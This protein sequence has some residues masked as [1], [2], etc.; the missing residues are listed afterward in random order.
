VGP[1]YSR[2]GREKRE[3]PAHRGCAIWSLGPKQ[4]PSI[5]GPRLTWSTPG[6]GPSAQRN[7]CLG[8]RGSSWAG[9]CHGG[10]KG[11]LTLTVKT[12]SA[13][14]RCANR[15]LATVCYGSAADVRIGRARRQL[16]NRQ[17]TFWA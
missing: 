8:T 16:L 1:I 10:S 6:H 17:R 4:D 3:G 7:Y 15:L 14:A 11:K 2:G 13:R 9:G 12:G 5:G